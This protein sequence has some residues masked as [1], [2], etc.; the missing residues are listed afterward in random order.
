ME[1]SIRRDGCTRQRAADF[2]K[3]SRSVLSTP[4]SSLGNFVAQQHRLLFIARTFAKWWKQKNKTLT[5]QTTL[6]VAGLY[7]VVCTTGARSSNRPLPKN[8]AYRANTRGK[9]QTTTDCPPDSGQINHA[10]RTPHQNNSG[11]ST[12][13]LA[14]F[15]PGL[16]EPLLLFQG[17]GVP[18]ADN[19]AETA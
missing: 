14:V 4:F 15:L 2:P 10:S 1:L 5:G 13:M 11:C 16:H 7:R 9:K 17:D 12:M 19:K 6:S 3:V 18:L 8:D